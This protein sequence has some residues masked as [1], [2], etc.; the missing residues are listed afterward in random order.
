MNLSCKID[1]NNPRIVY[2]VSQVRELSLASL[3]SVRVRTSDMRRSHILVL[4]LPD[5]HSIPAI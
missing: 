4:A 5:I 1:T 3:C 2:R